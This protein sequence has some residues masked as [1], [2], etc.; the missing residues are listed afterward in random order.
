MSSLEV[1]SALAG[2]FV[3]V[4]GLARLLERRPREVASYPAE[5]THP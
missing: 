2:L 5:D 3:I 1:V 4:A